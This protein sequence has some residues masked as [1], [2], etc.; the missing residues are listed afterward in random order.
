MKVSEREA[1]AHAA[2]CAEEFRVHPLGFFFLKYC[3]GN[4][5][6]RRIHVWLGNNATRTTNQ[7]HLHSFDIESVVVVGKIRNEL[8]RYRETAGGAVMEFE[9]SYNDGKSL[10]RR[11][12][13]VGELDPMG[14]FETPAGSW[15]RLEA[16]VIHRV[17]V[18]EAPCVTL[19][20]TIERGTRI[21][22]YGLTDEEQPC[23][24]RM[25]NREEVSQIAAALDGALHP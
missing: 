21:C 20:S 10:L 4:E 11:T 22:S 17:I 9:V 15:Y 14:S 25:V 5:Q 2:N 23:V 24:R 8:F 18:E 7:L 1:L 6:A 12:G 16:G 3:A 19:V 13:S